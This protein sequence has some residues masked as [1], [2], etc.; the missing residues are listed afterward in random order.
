MRVFSMS[1]QEFDAKAEARLQVTESDS[2]IF[3]VPWPDSNQDSLPTT[4]F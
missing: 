3:L 4:R 2:G 1:E